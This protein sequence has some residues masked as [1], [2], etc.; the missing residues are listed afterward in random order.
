MD[1]R[2]TIVILVNLNIIYSLPIE[3]VG[4]SSDVE[5]VILQTVEHR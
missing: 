1:K 2:S 5:K 3:V 4:D